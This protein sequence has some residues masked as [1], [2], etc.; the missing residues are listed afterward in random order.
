MYM[1]TQCTYIHTHTC[2]HT[3]THT[4]IH[5][6]IVYTD[7]HT[8]VHIYL[9]VHTIYYVCVHSMESMKLIL[10]IYLHCTSMYSYYMYLYVT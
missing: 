5:T 10:S 6:Y 4:Y 1:Y 8:Y 2:I 3:Y 9:Y 7:K